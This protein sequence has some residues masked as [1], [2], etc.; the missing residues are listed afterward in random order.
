MLKTQFAAA[1]TLIGGPT[2]LIEA[3]GLRLLTDPTFD[4]PGTYQLPHVTL[5][6]RA[7]PALAVHNDSW[8]HFTESREDLERA[9]AALGLAGR[10]RALK[11]GTAVRLE[12]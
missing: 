4:G 2:V 12:L 8:A 11:T 7:G 6:K 1:L 10:L 3:G 9:F 5:E